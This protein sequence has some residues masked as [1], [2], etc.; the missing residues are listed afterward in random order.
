VKQKHPAVASGAFRE[1]LG[2]AVFRANTTVGW[3]QGDWTI[4][5]K[6]NSAN[7][8]KARLQAWQVFHSKERS[9]LW[10]ASAVGITHGTRENTAQ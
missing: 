8:Q 2:D 1:K 5:L 4:S 6:P 9:M 7:F 10:D 3:E